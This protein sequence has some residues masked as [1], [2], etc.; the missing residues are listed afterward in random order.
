MFFGLQ[1]IGIHIE[2]HVGQRQ[3]QLNG[4]CPAVQH[5][6][7]AMP[8]LIGPLHF[9]HPVRTGMMTEYL[10][11]AYIGADAAADALFSVDDRGQDLLLRKSENSVGR[12]A[13]KPVCMISQNEERKISH[14]RYF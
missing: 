1:R 2:Q 4:S 9:R 11:G 13:F 3:T 5:T 14:V 7:I 12:L 10:K 8:A 6:G